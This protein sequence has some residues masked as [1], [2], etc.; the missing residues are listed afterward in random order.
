MQGD[1]FEEFFAPELEKNGYAAV[2][3]KK[4]G[5]IYTGTTYT[6]D[7]CA[8]FFRR[9]RFSL[10]KKYEVRT[11]RLPLPSSSLETESGSPRYPLSSIIFRLFSGIRHPQGCGGRLYV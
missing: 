2:Y 8:T 7:G 10:V 9:E 4:T 3:K 1:H 6:I 11:R 5:E